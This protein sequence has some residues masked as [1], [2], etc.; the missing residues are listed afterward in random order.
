[1]HILIHYIQKIIQVKG[2][3]D[4]HNEICSCSQNPES[5][6][7]DLCPPNHIP[8][9]CGGCLLFGQNSFQCCSWGAHLRRRAFERIRRGWGQDHK[10]SDWWSRWG[11]GKQ[12]NPDLQRLDPWQTWQQRQ[13][14][15][16]HVKPWLLRAVDRRW[17]MM[18][19]NSG[20]LFQR[21]FQHIQKQSDV[22]TWNVSGS[23]TWNIPKHTHLGQHLLSIV[24]NHFYNSSH[25]KASSVGESQG[26]E[27][28]C[29]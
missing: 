26:L 11:S 15:V 3:T 17:V 27:S 21:F 23:H 24:S 1:M 5:Q 4:V 22:A 16:E 2:C 25:I 7:M 12:W 19:C 8:S 29:R 18:S 13:Q 9:Y 14:H 6:C 20:Q 10:V 28:S